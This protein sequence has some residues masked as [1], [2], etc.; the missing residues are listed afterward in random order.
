VLDLLRVAAYCCSVCGSLCACAGK[1]GKLE[2][3][4]ELKAM[5]APKAAPLVSAHSSAQWLSV[6]ATNDGLA[7]SGKDVVAEQRKLKMAFAD[8]VVMVPRARASYFM[9]QQCCVRERSW[10]CDQGVFRALRAC[11]MYA[12]LRVLHPTRLCS[13]LVCLLLP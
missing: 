8:Q 13:L 7:S 6:L 11:R 10:V 4:G 5:H 1:Y 12:R 3:R 2:R 9:M